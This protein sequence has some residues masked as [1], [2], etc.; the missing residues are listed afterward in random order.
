MIKLSGRLNELLKHLDGE[1]VADVGCDHG[2]I[3]VYCALKG[4]RTVATDIS[5]QSLRKAEQLAKKHSAELK[6]V[7]CDGLTGIENGEVENVLI[8][9]MG[10][11]EIVKILSDGF[12]HNKKFNK[13]VLSPNSEAKAVRE[14]L[15]TEKIGISRDYVIE[16]MNKF[17]SII[18]AGD[19]DFKPLNDFELEFGMEY[20]TCD[21]S[22]KR[23][24]KEYMQLKPIADKLAGDSKRRFILLE[25]LNEIVRT[26]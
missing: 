24:K 22:I 20:K 5:E 3:A 9:G 14:F 2:K 15:Q 13:Y 25:N 7:L 4:K 21:A 10:G 11:I 8:A 16:D 23:L 19:C 1:S 26:E 6:T 12:A 17:Y 18:V